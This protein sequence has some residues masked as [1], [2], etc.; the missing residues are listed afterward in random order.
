MVA[1]N[2]PMTAVSTSFFAECVRLGRRIDL[3]RLTI[4][5]GLGDVGIAVTFEVRTKQDVT[6]EG[7]GLERD[8]TSR[9]LVPVTRRQHEKFSSRAFVD[10]QQAR[11][12]ERHLPDGDDVPVERSLGAFRR[13]I[14]NHWAVLRVEERHEADRV[15]VGSECL[16]VPFHGP[17]PVNDLIHLPS[18]LVSI[19]SVFTAGIPPTPM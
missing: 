19:R 17:P 13:Q 7:V 12:L 1:R 15:G 16:V 4:G 18:V 2:P 14:E 8:V 9:R 11:I 3:Q 5:D 6:T 10:S